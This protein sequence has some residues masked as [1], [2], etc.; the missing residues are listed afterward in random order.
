MKLTIEATGDTENDVRQA[1]SEA[2]DRFDAGNTSGFDRNA[3]GSFTFTVEGEPVE[4]EQ[5]E[6]ALA[7]VRRVA[8]VRRAPIRVGE[9]YPFYAEMQQ[10]YEPPEKRLR[11]YT[12][13]SVTVIAEADPQDRD[14]D[15]AVNVVAFVVRAEDGFEFTALAEELNGWD[16][17]LGQ[18][19][20]PDATYGP[21]HDRRFLANERDA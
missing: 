4:P 8:A 15:D 9:R 20:W 1:V 13:Q 14:D 5:V 19:F 7:V 6:Q 16:F 18:Y 2:M 11:N 3:T 17:D 21:R 12:G 10:E